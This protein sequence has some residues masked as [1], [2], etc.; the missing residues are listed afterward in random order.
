[1]LGCRLFVVCLIVAGFVLFSAPCEAA[2]RFR[3]F[4][5]SHAGLVSQSGISP[6]RVGSH[7][8]VGVSSIS[9]EDTRN[10]ACFWGKRQ[11]LSVQYSKR[12]S[13]FYAVVR[14]N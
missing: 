14:Y 9:Y 1:M 10:R 2:G 12:G 5:S 6:H 11:H 8:G 7:E 13:M 4:G 3:L